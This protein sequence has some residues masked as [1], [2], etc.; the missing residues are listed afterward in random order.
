[1]GKQFRFFTEMHFPPYTIND[2]YENITYENTCFTLTS[3]EDEELAG[4]V[5]A[6]EVEPPELGLAAAA[7]DREVAD[8]LPR[9]EAAWSDHIDL[10]LC[11]CLYRVEM[12]TKF[13][14]FFTIFE[15]A[16]ALPLPSQ[17]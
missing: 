11:Q 17:C 12:S 8:G 16:A 3:P 15:Q 6:V 2:Y 5:S 13:R 1:M 7:V 10:A 14:D 9:L 4:L